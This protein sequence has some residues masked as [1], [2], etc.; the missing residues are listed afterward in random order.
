MNLKNIDFLV[1][2]DGEISIGRAGPVNCVATATDPDQ[3]LA[4]L[5][6]RKGESLSNLLVRLDA[7][8]EDALER[9]IYVDE[10]NDGTR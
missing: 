7:A 3:C 2:S 6:R 9:E 8:I 4:M 10:L 5:V 1:Q